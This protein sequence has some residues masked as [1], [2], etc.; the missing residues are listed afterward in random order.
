MELF[1]ED[2]RREGRAEGR[3]EGTMQTLI[4]LVKKGLISIKDAAAQAKLSE[5]AFTA[6]MKAL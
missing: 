1:R 6:K 4:E 3:T 2:G 5:D